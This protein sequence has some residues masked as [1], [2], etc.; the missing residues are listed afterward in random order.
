LLGVWI[1]APAALATH[2]LRPQSPLV[3]A[4]VTG[5]FAIFGSL[6]GLVFG[7]LGGIAIAIAHLRHVRRPAPRSPQLEAALSSF[8][9]VPIGYFVVSL[10]IET[11]RYR[12]LVSADPQQPG[13]QIAI[14]ATV[15]A[16]VG[17][18]AL[19]RFL[20]RTTGWTDARPIRALGF[21]ALVLGVTTLPVRTSA[22]SNVAETAA[23]ELV[24][25]REA[26]KHAPLLVVGLDGG[27]WQTIQPL[28]DSGQ[29]PAL[30]RLIEQGQHG[31]V[32]A[33]WPPYWSGP[34]WAAIVT[35]Q[36]PDVTGVKG[37][38]LASAPGLPPFH[39]PLELDVRLNPLY[40]SELVLILNGVESVVPMPRAQLKRP[41]VWERVAAAGGSVG[42]I[43]FPFTYPAD[44]QAMTIVSNLVSR[45]LWGGLVDPA[46]LDVS[47]V[48]SPRALGP[49]ISARFAE[50]ENSGSQALHEIFPPGT[51]R[52]PPKTPEHPI[53]VLR[54]VFD[55]NEKTF[56]AAEAV[57]TSG[58][59][60]DLVM[61]HVSSFDSICHAFWKFR[62]PEGF[63]EHID[64]SD[65]AAL[66]PVID[67]YL[68]YLDRRLQRVFSLMPGANIVVIA[69]HG[70]EAVQDHVMW[71]GWHG[72]EGIFIAAGPDVAADTRRV[73]ASYFDIVPMVLDLLGFQRSP[74]LT[75]ANP[76][77]GAR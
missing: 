16:C 61:L 5:I 32:D 77:A 56:D 31:D 58:R 64:P 50:A 42:V 67:R 33:L 43:R 68:V 2:H 28:V 49:A 57:L 27:N 35:G 13:V 23:P 24:R 12:R 15:T 62:F 34:A 29:M 72:R 74:D 38:L 44:D 60:F 8:A 59:P 11:A 70:E 9:A 25:T 21:F 41:P 66:G 48:V 18:L 45:D 7:G 55:M 46:H 22:E 3:W 40:A 6:S 73:R 63:R 69:D 71:S 14:V 75:G 53:G 30:A 54:Q 39:V 52:W 36:P 51:W 65:V 4:R 76:L 37:D 20:V 47:R 17:L 19:Y 10:A 26:T 1:V